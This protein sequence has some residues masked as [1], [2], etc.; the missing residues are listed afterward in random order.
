MDVRS[1]KDETKEALVGNRLML[2]LVFIVYAAI[3]IVLGK[4]YI[5][6]VLL[7]IFSAG[8]YLVY[9]VYFQERR[10]DIEKMFDFFKNL[11]HALKL[12]GVFLL[13]ALFIFIGTIFFVIPGIIL[14]L[15][16][17]QASLIMADN[18]TI[19]VW[20]AMQRSKELMD[21]HKMEFFGVILTIIGHFILGLITLG[22]YLA[23]IIPYMNGLVFNYYLHLSYQNE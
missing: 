12:L 6:L 20:D 18:P 23:Y 4:F 8:Y 22:I 13:T 5:G 10:V 11:N 1:I 15:Q 9:K 14:Y 21:G 19:E 2:L 7:P 17:S 3:N 16:Y